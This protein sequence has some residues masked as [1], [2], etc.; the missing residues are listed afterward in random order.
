[1]RPTPIPLDNLIRPT[2]HTDPPPT[3]IPTPPHPYHHSPTHPPANTRSFPSPRP[4]TNAKIYEI[5]PRTH[6]PQG[7]SVDKTNHLPTIRYDHLS[8]TSQ[9]GDAGHDIPN[10]TVWC[11]P[12]LPSCSAVG[13][14][15]WTPG[16]NNRSPRPPVVSSRNLADSGRTL[17]KAIERASNS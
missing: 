10:T 16:G 3:V 1:M 8:H 13:C 17:S 7:G 15:R 11:V 6:H 12:A 5:I 4:P 2:T 14:W 9:C